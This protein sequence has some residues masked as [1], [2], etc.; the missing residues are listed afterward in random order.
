MAPDS[1]SIAGIAAPGG[2]AHPSLHAIRVRQQATR[3]WVAPPSGSRQQ[4]AIR[5]GSTPEGTRIDVA[6]RAAQAAARYFIRGLCV[7]AAALLQAGTSN[8]QKGSTSG[9]QG[10][11]VVEGTG[12]RVGGQNAIR[13]GHIAGGALEL[14]E[15]A[16]DSPEA[17]DIAED[18]LDL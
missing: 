4:G 16:E 14:G 5:R 1:P 13:V 6:A 9:A 11:G 10:G 17:K 2:N 15:F 8:D 18:V 3:R 7:I 12:T